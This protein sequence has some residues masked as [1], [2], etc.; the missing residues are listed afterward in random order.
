MT[1]RHDPDRTV[2]E[3]LEE[4]PNALP[5]ITR[6]AIEVGVRTTRQ[7]RRRSLVPRWWSANRLPA[8]LVLGA[9]AVLVALGGFYLS[10]PDANRLPGGVGAGPST[11]QPPTARPSAPRPSHVPEIAETFT[12]SIHGYS[13]GYPARW[14]AT[15]AYV[16]WW[17]PT[18]K[19]QQT[20]SDD[21]AFFDFLS[22]PLGSTAFRA[23]SATAP[24]GVS[25]DDWVDEFMTFS[26]EAG[27]APARTTQPT[28][29]IDGHEGRVR[30]SCGEVEATVAVER[31]VYLFT[32]Y[33]T[34]AETRATELRDV[35]DALAA[36]I[37][38]R[39]EDAVNSGPPAG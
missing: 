22:S 11:P 39:P 5:D 1:T 30:A 34:D 37:D 4:G 14:N 31:R 33:G 18:W 8:R 6:R 12:S 35:F 9:L 7:T 13:V 20:E 17:P 26:D 16:P 36:T 27:C 2:S 29:V 32:L 21:T 25:I 19:Q 3:W 15:S 24:D 10:A 38:L 23:A 28:I